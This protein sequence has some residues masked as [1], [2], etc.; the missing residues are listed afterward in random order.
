MGANR[1]GIG[2]TLDVE[3]N[4]SPDAGASW[5]QPGTPQPDL[6]ARW[7]NVTW[8]I[9]AKGALKVTHASL[10][11]G[12]N[13]LNTPNLLRAAGVRMLVGA[14]ASHRLHLTVDLDMPAAGPTAN[15]GQELAAR[16]LSD[17][18]AVSD[19][20]YS[21]M[22]I[23]Y[24]LRDP[25]AELFL[26]PMSDLGT[27]ER[28]PSRLWTPDPVPMRPDQT[29]QQASQASSRPRRLDARDMIVTR[30]PGT[31][32]T[33]GLSRRLF[34]ACRIIAEADRE[35]LDS[36]NDLL[37][38]LMAYE[39]ET[40]EQSP[41]P[42]TIRNDMFLEQT[43]FRERAFFDDTVYA[44]FSRVTERPSR[45]TRVNDREIVYSAPNPRTLESATSDVYI[46][47]DIDGLWPLLTDPRQG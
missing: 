41:D 32:V 12:A 20:A 11:K 31:A 5:G 22:L 28:T 33:V 13:Q 35:I 4:R 1:L 38:D 6:F 44:E 2:P 8:L 16:T 17:P 24:L 9:E 18:A 36:A 27:A 46:A 14:N 21:R 29:D 37:A 7:V 25:T 23:Y 19:L 34:A 42:D 43:R 30:V 10:V 3:T 45:E 47:I 26:R 15:R 40:G 39:A